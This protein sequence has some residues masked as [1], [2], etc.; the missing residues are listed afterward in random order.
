MGYTGIIILFAFI[1]AWLFVQSL[2]TFENDES[3]L[4]KVLGIIICILTSIVLIFFCVGLREEIRY[5]ALEDY[6]NGKI[7]V[8]ENQQTVRT[9]K[10]IK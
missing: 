10:Q 5:N 3:T 9:Y 1:L 4:Y 6:F 2:K 7:E 8:V